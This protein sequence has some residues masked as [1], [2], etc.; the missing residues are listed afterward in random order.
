LELTANLA[1]RRFLEPLKPNRTVRMSNEKAV[2]EDSF[3][4]V[5]TP[6]APSPAPETQDYGVRT[7]SVRPLNLTSCKIVY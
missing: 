2:S 1:S 4:F 7:T 5:D 6:A 3:E